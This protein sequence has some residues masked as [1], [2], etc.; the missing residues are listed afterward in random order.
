PGCSRYVGAQ[1]AGAVFGTILG[2]LMF[3]RPAMTVASTVR[4]GGNLLLSEVVATAGLLVLIAALVRT[5]R[6]AAGPGAVGAYVGAACWFTASTCFANPAVTVARMFTGAEA[7]IAPGSVP[8]FLLAQAGGL[9]L[10]CALI[11]WLY[12]RPAARPEPAVTAVP[13]GRAPRPARAARMLTAV[14]VRRVPRPAG[15]PKR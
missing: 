14:P 7:G 5:G 15:R 4:S 9:I 1:L 3:G 2:N 8:G 11:S 6:G 12:P 13:V 10:A